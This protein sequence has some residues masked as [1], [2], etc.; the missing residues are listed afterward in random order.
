MCT[1]AWFPARAQ[2]WAGSE[3]AGTASRLQGAPPGAASWGGGASLAGDFRS[4]P[5]PL[6]PT[7]PGSAAGEAMEA[8]RV[9][10][11]VPAPSARGLWGL[12]RRSLRGALCPGRVRC[13]Q[14]PGTGRGG[15]G[16]SVAVKGPRAACGTSRRGGDIGLRNALPEPLRAA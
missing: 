9:G 13:P 4:L 11:P 8:G 3:R 1:A 10:A 14:Q 16:P 12:G 2:V 6:S 15:R 5:G 7:A